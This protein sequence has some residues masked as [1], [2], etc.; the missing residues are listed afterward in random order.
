[1]DGVA[2]VDS[3]DVSSLV[4]EVEEVSRNKD[5]GRFSGTITNALARRLIHDLASS[6]S[7]W[8]S[9]DRLMSTVRVENDQAVL[10]A[11]AEL[12]R[13]GAT[14]KTKGENADKIA[15]Q[16]LNAR[17]P[18]HFSFGDGDQRYYAAVAWQR[19]GFPLQPAEAARTAVLEGSSD[20]A[21]RAWLRLLLLGRG[22]AGTLQD[23]ARAL[24]ELQW[25]RLPS[26]DRPFDSSKERSRRVALLLK[27]IRAEL[28]DDHVEGDDDVI[29]ALT[30]LVKVA[31]AY[32]SG[33]DRYQ[34]RA[35]AV[36]E[37]VSL[38]LHI[39]R[40]R[41]RLLT[42]PGIYA[43]ATKTSRWLPSGG[44]RRI[45][46]TSKPVERLRATLIEGLVLLLKQ[47]K[48]SNELAEVHRQLSPT[49]QQAKDQLAGVAVEE[50]DLPPAARTWLETGE[51]SVEA[52]DMEVSE[53]D[54]TAIALAL[55]AAHQLP[56]FDVSKIPQEASG[57]T[58]V[59][60]AT[61]E[62]LRQLV[63]HSKELKH[64]VYSLARRRSLSVFGDVGTV[65]DFSPH[66]HRHT[67]QGGASKVEVVRPGVEATG[68]RGSKVIVRAIVT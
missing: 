23:V 55:L 11:L 29:A 30:D 1:M 35:K 62:E 26:S 64:R 41:F 50:R 39:I 60:P 15:F 68:R 66:A 54:D 14:L 9:V 28:D 24:G 27:G 61:A 59:T 49:P 6:P 10:L 8:T 65:I 7:F 18:A 52:T 25:L 3:D 5:L 51:Y 37:F 32:V 20:K 13:L 36:D 16:L 4:G 53:T 43:T 17:V 58:T 22:A 42:E 33:P 47:G 19:S 21:R 44:W 34:D 48:V 31:F 38:V 67:G 56:T 46:S 45:T 40:T 12:G 63:D 57:Q 2:V